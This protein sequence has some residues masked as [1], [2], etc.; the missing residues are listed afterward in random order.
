MRG[1]VHREATTCHRSP[2]GESA[3]AEDAGF[4]SFGEI[5]MGAADVWSRDSKVSCGVARRLRAA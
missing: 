2:Q 1:P 4:R 3:L 5:F